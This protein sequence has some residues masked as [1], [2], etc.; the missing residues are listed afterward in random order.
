MTCKLTILIKRIKGII[1]HSHL[2]AF[3]MSFR[4]TYLYFYRVS[5]SQLATPASLSMPTWHQVLL[6]CNKFRINAMINEKFPII[7]FD[8]SL[9]HP[10][11]FI[12]L[13]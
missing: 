2:S 6:T 12:F 11:A 8:A 9:F 7:Q 1:F 13:F 5:G 3:L 10:Y 4:Y